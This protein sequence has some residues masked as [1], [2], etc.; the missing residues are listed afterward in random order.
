MHCSEVE[1]SECMYF[2][3]LY[4]KQIVYKDR[5]QKNTPMPQVGDRCE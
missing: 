1:T 3:K 5:W 2:E 4:G